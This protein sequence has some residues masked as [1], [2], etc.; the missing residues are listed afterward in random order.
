MSFSMERSKFR[1]FTRISS[2]ELVVAAAVI[3][4]ALSFG[5]IKEENA[6]VKT[7]HTYEQLADTNG[8]GKL[9]PDESAEVYRILGMKTTTP[10][11]QPYIPRLEDSDYM[12]Y[13]SI[14]KSKN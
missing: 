4:T 5:E 11:G 14:R 13:I 3:T 8:D 10:E 9:T 1:D 6:K 12:R 7:F 2:I